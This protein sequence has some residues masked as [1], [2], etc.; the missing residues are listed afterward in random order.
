M[1]ALIIGLLAASA[2]AEGAEAPPPRKQKNKNELALVRDRKLPACA[3][4]SALFRFQPC[5]MCVSSDAAGACQV[6]GHFNWIS[7]VHRGV[8]SI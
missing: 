4:D 2:V 7:T 6:S 1:W 3:A 8:R 5:V